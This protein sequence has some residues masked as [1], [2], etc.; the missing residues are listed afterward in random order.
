MPVLRSHAVH[1][2]SPTE[3]LG[4]TMASCLKVDAPVAPSEMSEGCC[5]RGKSD[6][7]E[8]AADR[9]KRHERIKP[10][11]LRLWQQPPWLPPTTMRRKEVQTQIDQIY[12]L[13]EFDL[14]RDS[15]D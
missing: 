3:C 2:E 6:Q 1:R 10:H 14:T 12:L 13:F 8:V 11:A 7:S 9:E 15:S 5:A 4:E